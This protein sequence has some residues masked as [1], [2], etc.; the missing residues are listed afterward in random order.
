[1]NEEERRFVRFFLLLFLSLFWK[2]KELK[3]LGFQAVFPLLSLSLSLTHTHTHTHTHTGSLDFPNPKSL[4]RRTQ[5]GG[6]RE[7]RILVEVL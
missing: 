7:V 5:R 3:E 6:L 2:K 1:M 4:L